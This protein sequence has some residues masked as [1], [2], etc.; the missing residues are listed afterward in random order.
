DPFIPLAGRGHIL[1]TTR[2]HASGGLAQHI[3]LQKMEPETGTLFLL[4]RTGFLP[5]Q[6]SLEIAGM[7]E[8]VEAGKISQVLDG[9]PLAL[10]QAGAYIK[11]TSCGLHEYLEL[12]Q[13]RRQELL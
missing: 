6:A 8:C 10:D 7:E 3:E 4:R 9:L 11:E 12:Y 2:S 1:L 13:T 5:L